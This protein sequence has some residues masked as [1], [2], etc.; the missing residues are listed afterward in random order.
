MNSMS[1]RRSGGY[2]GAVEI[3]EDCLHAGLEATMSVADVD[4]VIADDYPGEF[5]F[6]AFK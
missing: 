1:G 2:G 4:L 5:T 3:G 6:M